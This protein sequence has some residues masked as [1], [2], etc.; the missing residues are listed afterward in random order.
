MFEGNAT[1]VIDMMGDIK[2]RAEDIQRIFDTFDNN[3]CKRVEKY[4][5]WVPPVWPAYKLNT[6]GAR[7]A[8]GLALAGGLIRNAHGE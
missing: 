8:L 5:G 4:F 1:N 6:D 7:K 2:S 3:K